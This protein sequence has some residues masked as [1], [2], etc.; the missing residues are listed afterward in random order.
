MDINL[1]VNYLEGT[2][3]IDFNKTVISKF[4]NLV[5]QILDAQKKHHSA[6]SES[7]KKHHQ[8]KI[9]LIDNQIDELVYKL[10]GLTDKEIEVV[11]GR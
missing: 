7:D 5:D 10:Y 1:K 3:I 6:K 9:D 2:K 8:Q 4:C 11:E